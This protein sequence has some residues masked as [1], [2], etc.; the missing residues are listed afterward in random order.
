MINIIKVE[1]FR[2]RKSKILWVMLCLTVASPLL[3]ALFSIIVNSFMAGSLEN[4]GIALRSVDLTTQLLG[5]TSAL[6]GDATLWALIAS[7]VV[8]SKEF[9]DGTMRN[10]ILANKSRAQLYFG[11]LITS[12]IVACAYLLAYITVTLAIVAPIFGFSN[13]NAGQ[14]ITAVLCSLALGLFAIAFVQSCMCMFMFGVRKQWAT[15]LLPILV[16]L[17]APSVF[18]IIV[19]IIGYAK[20]YVG[21]SISEEALRFVP[22]INLDYLDLTNIDGAVVGMHILYCAVFT[23]VFVVSGYYTFKKADLK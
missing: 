20:L 16:C 14:A 13:L 2:L 1:L 15:I 21:Q 6:L 12:L 5:D 11:Y 3:M 7:A 22:F 17:F 10:V 4:L 19:Q 8:L 23:A 18:E 9:V